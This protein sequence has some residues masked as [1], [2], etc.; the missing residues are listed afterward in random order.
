MK[1]ILCLALALT[2][3]FLP[4]T[5]SAQTTSSAG[6]PT[7]ST[8]VK[9]MI[10]L[11]QKGGHILLIRH[12]RTAVPSSDDDYSK[13]PNDCFAQRN[14]SVAGV[15]SSAETGHSLRTLKIPVGQVFA[16]P[17]CRG[18]ETA[19]Y[20]FG[21]A[22]PEPR[23]MHHD[24]KGERTLEIAGTDLAAFL[25]ELNPLTTNFAVVSHAGNISKAVGVRVIEGAAAVLAKQA[26][27]SWK[28][29]GTFHGSELDAWARDA[30]TKQK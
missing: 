7:P 19:R 15:C 22:Q 20:M 26:D 16:S 10:S 28:A 12:E 23:L 13:A 5:T 2:T 29:I 24:P 27:G 30:L 18:M 6:A 8:S 9:D 4:V 14:L 25:K 3:L 1:N 21:I 11:L 17:M